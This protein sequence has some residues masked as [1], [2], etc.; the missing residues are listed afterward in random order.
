VQDKAIV[1]LFLMK[2]ILL[3][4]VYVFFFILIMID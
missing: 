3:F 2:F 4:V 1:A